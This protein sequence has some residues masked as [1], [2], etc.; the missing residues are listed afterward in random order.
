[1]VVLAVE[2]GLPLGSFALRFQNFR[3]SPV[4]KQLYVCFY[5][6]VIY[7]TEGD[8]VAVFKV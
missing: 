4:Q 6:V 7:M 2:T 1:M 8:S 3:I 5:S